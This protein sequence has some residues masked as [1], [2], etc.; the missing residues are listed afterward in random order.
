[1]PCVVK[2]ILNRF[3]DLSIEI[4]LIDT[5]ISCEKNWFF[6][7]QIGDHFFPNLNSGAMGI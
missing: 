3:T 1:M 4:N 7:L 5:H 6:T 2:P